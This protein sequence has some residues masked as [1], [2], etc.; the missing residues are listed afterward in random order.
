MYFHQ[1]FDHFYILLFLYILFLLYYILFCSGSWLEISI[2]PTERKLK[3]LKAHNPFFLKY[4]SKK[5]GTWESFL[6]HSGFLGELHGNGHHSGR[7]TSGGAHT[8][9]FI[10]NLQ[11]THTHTHTHNISPHRSNPAFQTGPRH[12]TSS[13]ADP[14]TVSPP[15]SDPLWGATVPGWA[16]LE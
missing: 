10:S 14:P 12:I 8:F 11:H 13:P 5:N 3:T 6:L 1:H 9:S 16:E 7:L 4:L 2:N 15:L